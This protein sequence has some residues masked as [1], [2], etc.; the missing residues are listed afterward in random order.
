MIVICYI[1]ASDKLLHFCQVFIIK[2]LKAQVSKL[3]PYFGKVRNKRVNIVYVEKEA[4]NGE[5]KRN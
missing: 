5:V 2:I 4:M 3:D 1:S